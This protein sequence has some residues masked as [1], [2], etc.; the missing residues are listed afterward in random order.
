MGIPAL[1]LDSTESVLLVRGP[2]ENG[3][4]R[5]PSSARASN[6]R[7]GY[8]LRCETSEGYTAVMNLPSSLSIGSRST[9]TIT[10]PGPHKTRVRK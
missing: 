1:D 5:F 8:F 10:L 7:E 3:G 6:R 4:F 2:A 9:E